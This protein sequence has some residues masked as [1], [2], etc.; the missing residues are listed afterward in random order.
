MTVSDVPVD[1]FDKLFYGDPKEIEQRL[2]VVRPQSLTHSDESLT[3]QIDSQIAL[4]QAMQKRYAEAFETLDRAEKLPGA[5]NPLARVR[6]LLERGRVFQQAKRMEE[7]VPWL[8]ASWEISSAH[9]LDY[10][11]VNAA[12]MVAIAVGSPAEKIRWNQIALDV[13]DASG[14]EKAQAWRVVLHNNLAQAFVA[15]GEFGNGLASFQSCQNLAREQGNVLIERGARWGIARCRRGLGDQATALQIQQE[16]LK[17]YNEVESQGLLPQE[18]LGMA[19]G[20]VYEELAELD[21]QNAAMFAK[22]AI[23]DLGVNDWFESIE[24]A[25]WQRLKTMAGN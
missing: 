17:E 14:D 10:H 3:P 8:V 12:H 16:L 2:L 15:A 7:A 23:S 24:P 19:R 18:L 1:E 11:T 13:A 22:H 5:T 20:M 21:R 9:S 4:V 6:L 25:R